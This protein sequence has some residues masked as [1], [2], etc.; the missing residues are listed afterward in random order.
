MTDDPPFGRVALAALRVLP[1]ETA[2]GLALQALRR[3][4]VAPAHGTDDPALATT[5][6]GLDFPNP[7]GLAA[8]FDKDAVALRPLLGRGFGFVEVGT[9]TP[10]PQPGNPRPRLFRLGLDDAVINRMGFNNRGMAAMADRLENRPAQGIVGVNIGPN[11]SFQDPVADFEVG[12]AG[13]GGL[14]DYLVINISSPNTPG[15]RGF[16]DKDRLVSVIAAARRARAAPAPL[17]VKIAPDLEADA[18]RDIAEIARGQAIDGLIVSNTTTARPTG[19]RS[20]AR[21]EAGGL[22]GRPLFVPS[23]R[24]LGEIYVLTEGRIPLIGV[25]GIGSGADAYAKIRAG[26]SLV[27]LYTALTYHGLGLVARIKAEL[28][29]LVARDGFT[30]VGQA[31][32]ADH[33][34][35]GGPPDD[36]I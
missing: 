16:Q 33:K 23:T 17:L 9:V 3:G 29:G 2:H 8:G 6:W 25:G 10:A 5:V 36:G 18:R 26:A 27:Q 28:A 21:A 20:P 12:I 7:I 14:A 1:P 19:L 24:L 35:G 31:V 4:L 15:L 13:L 32:G 34:P 11:R 30:S 22:S